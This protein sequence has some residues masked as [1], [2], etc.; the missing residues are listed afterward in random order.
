VNAVDRTIQIWERNP[1]PF[2]LYSEKVIWQKLGHIH[3]NPCQENWRLAALPELY[4]FSSARY[5]LLNEDDWG[6]SRTLVKPDTAWAS[7]AG[8][9]PATAQQ[10]APRNDN[11]A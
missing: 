10:R 1:L 11:L 6:S 4:R 8:R 5:Y 3:K 2:E 7:V 9:G